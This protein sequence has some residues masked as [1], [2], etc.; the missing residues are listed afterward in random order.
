MLVLVLVLEC[1]SVLAEISFEKVWYFHCPARA[2]HSHFGIMIFGA[3]SSCC[4]GI[5]FKPCFCQGRSISRRRTNTFH[6]R[7]NTIWKR[8]ETHGTEYIL[9]AILLYRFILIQIYFDTDFPLGMRDSNSF[10]RGLSGHF[11]SLSSIPIFH[12]SATCCRRCDRIL[13]VGTNIKQRVYG[14]SEVSS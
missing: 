8:K 5:A 4:P 2:V 6:G 7:K 14:R 1:Q 10:C 9:A 11:V 12:T 13:W 3:T